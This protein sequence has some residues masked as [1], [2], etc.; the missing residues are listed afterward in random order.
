MAPIIGKESESFSKRLIY[1]TSSSSYRP[2]WLVFAIGVPIIL[3]FLLYFMLRRR[4]LKRRSQGIEQIPYTG[5][6]TM[7]AQTQQQPYYQ[8]PFQPNSQYQP[9]IDQYNNQTETGYYRPQDQKFQPP[10]TYQNAADDPIVGSSSSTT[11]N[12]QAPAGPPP[13]MSETQE[14]TYPPQ[15]YTKGST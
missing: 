3:I 1:Y 6:T 5:W 8:Q 9:G 2:W 10:P 15:S 11:P 7:G 12:Y 4:N 14:P 13:G